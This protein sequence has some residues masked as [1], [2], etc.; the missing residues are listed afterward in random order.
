MP[1]AKKRALSTSSESSESDG[2]EEEKATEKVKKKTHI[3]KKLKPNATSSSDEQG[4]AKKSKKEKEKPKEAQLSKEVAVPVKEPEKKKLDLEK[5]V[6]T[7]TV[8]DMLRLKR[9]NLARKQELG[10][11]TSSGATTATDNDDEE[12]ESESVSSLAVS[13]SS[14]D[15]HPETP[16]PVNGV[17]EIPMPENL[18]ADVNAMIS[19]LKV[20][21]EA[22]STST[23]F[24]DVQLMDQLVKVDNIVKNI[25]ANVRVQTYNY[26][27]QFMPCTKKTLFEKVRKHRQGQFS[28]KVKVEVNK[29]RKIVNEAMPALIAKFDNDMKQYELK[30]SVQNVVGDNTTENNLPRKKFHWN[31]T[32]RKVLSNILTFL[33]DLHKATKAKKENSKEFVTL[34]FKEEVLPLWPEGWVKV[35]DFEKEIEKKKKKDARVLAPTITQGGQPQVQTKPNTASATKTTNGKA[36]AQKTDTTAN[37]KLN[38]KT[39]S[40]PELSQSLT[41]LSSLSPAS[42]IKRSSDHSINS[43]ISASP[44]PPATGK[45]PEV[46]KPRVIDLEKLSNPSDLLK[47]VAPKTLLARFS[48]AS[49]ID[50]TTPEKATISRRSDSSDS[51][52]V[53]VVSSDFNPIKPE[54]SLYNNNNN[55]VNHHTTQPAPI[56]KKMKKHGSDDGE[57]ETD[58]SKIIM[59]LQSLTVRQSFFSNIFTKYHSNTSFNP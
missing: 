53:E 47:V 22:N 7:T 54:K 35:E 25:S 8:K 29:L 9:D 28:T 32:S 44:S 59:G 14:R 27:S 48:N 37:Q 55:K 52:C 30:K 10:K 34:K 57:Q 18:P 36:P 42:V 39:N 17:K 11:S 40:T 23:K 38:G 3:E 21:A 33:E 19:S 26:M 45:A 6:K 46:T 41:N 58:Y 2:A 4:K 13:E 31:D 49:P 56:A 43:I 51:D 15:S 16:A 50:I 5:T 20:N 24:F 1:K 12:G